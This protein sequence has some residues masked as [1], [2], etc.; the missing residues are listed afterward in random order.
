MREGYLHLCD[1]LAAAAR[2]GVKLLMAAM[3]VDVLLGVFFRYVLGNALSWTEETARYIM[4]WTGFLGT[5][6]ALREGNHVAVDFL[7]LK[8]SGTARRAMVLVIRLLSLVFLLSVVGAGLLLLPRVSSQ[9]TPALAISM[10]WPYLAVPLGCL[11][12]ALEMVAV[13]LR[14]PSGRGGPEA[15]NGATMPSAG[16]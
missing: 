4:I 11:L 6:L 14:D 5:G 10:M 8:L 1:R 3:T 2:F 7:L 15:V 12:T 9:T 16:G 13:M